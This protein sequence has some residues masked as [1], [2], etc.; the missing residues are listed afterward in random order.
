VATLA[1]TV[2]TAICALL[3]AGSAALLAT[4]PQPSDS[5]A[6]VTL[7]DVNVIATPRG[8]EYVFQT[9]IYQVDV[10][11]TATNK[12]RS[13]PTPDNLIADAVPILAALNGLPQSALATTFAPYGLFVWG[14]IP[15]QQVTSTVVGDNRQSTCGISLICR[16]NTP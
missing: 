6:Q 1:H 13:T 10:L 11:V 12:P 8:E 3:S 4:N 14:V 9:G 2:E 15:S 5:T 7:P 16:F